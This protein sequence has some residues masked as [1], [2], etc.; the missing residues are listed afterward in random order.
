MCLITLAYRQSSQWP[1][2][3]VAN[4]DEFYQRPTL[5]VHHWEDKPIL[6]GRDL[7]QGGTWLGISD[8]GRLAALTNYRDGRSNQ[9]PLFSR[10]EL[11]SNYLATPMAALD[12]CREISFEAY[13]GFNLL[14]SDRTGL[15]Y[16]GTHHQTPTRLQP[17][18]HTLSNAL[19]NTPWPKTEL[20]HRQMQQYL[21][22]MKEPDAAQL[23]ELISSRDKASEEMLPDT[24][25]SQ[26]WEKM[27]S[28]CFIESDHYGTRSS[29]TLLLNASGELELTE[30]THP[31]PNT[32][33][34]LIT[35]FQLRAIVPD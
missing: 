3:L 23:L 7:T 6:A 21:S 26:E 8:D 11:V 17:G 30:F 19:L 13:G 12:Y 35:R 10:G 32:P 31:Q 33:Q 25:I 9:S 16:L 22:S 2:L 5:P 29:T 28:S 34:S 24:G 14:L 20:A 18:I 15:Y 27:L 4:R 1:L